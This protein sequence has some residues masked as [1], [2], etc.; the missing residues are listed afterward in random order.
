MIRF[1][2]FAEAFG[3]QSTGKHNILETSA[4]EAY[5]WASK[6]FSRAGMDIDDTLPEFRPNYDVAQHKASAGTK[7]RSEMP[8]LG[9]KDIPGFIE[10]LLAGGVSIHNGTMMISAMNPIQREIYLDKAIQGILDY[11]V[12]SSRK[13]ITTDTRFILSDELSIIEGHH[14]FLTGVLIWPRL[15]VRCIKVDLPQETLLQYA[16]MHA[17]KVGNIQNEEKT[18][19]R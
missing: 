6:R 9:G 10:S 1:K 15:S 11:G 17:D 3:G 19:E 16:Q 4:D 8:V 13:F 12:P 18:Y 7:L 14:R 5:E 2:Q